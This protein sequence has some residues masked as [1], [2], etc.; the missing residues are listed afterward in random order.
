MP[1]RRTALFIRILL[2]FFTFSSFSLAILGVVGFAF[3][4]KT[5]SYLDTYRYCLLMNNDGIFD[6]GGGGDPNGIGEG[7]I[8]I[9]LSKRQLKYE[10][11]FG[12]IDTPT[13]LAINGP[14]NS[15]SAYVADQFFP[16]TGSIDTLT[17][18]SDGFYRG[19]ATISSGD[20][21]QIIDNPAIFYLLLKTSVYTNGAI[22][23][24]LGEE[25]R[26]KQ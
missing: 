19:T 8:Q 26:N 22:G 11:L 12:G 10:I 15:T 7:W 25:C 3:S 4:L 24:R 16:D 2:G 1:V 9:D 6:D 13:N 18:D 23:T 14:L 5:R 21:K 17:P 20:A